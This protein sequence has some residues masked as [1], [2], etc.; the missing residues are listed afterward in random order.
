MTQK[1]PEEPLLFFPGS[2]NRFVDIQGFCGY[3]IPIVFPFQ[4]REVP[5]FRIPAGDLFLKSLNDPARQIIRAAGP[6]VGIFIQG[7]LF[8]VCDKIT[9]ASYFCR[10]GRIV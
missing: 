3:H 7:D 1:K 10:R 9:V 6:E 4:K 2:Q 8:R 5:I